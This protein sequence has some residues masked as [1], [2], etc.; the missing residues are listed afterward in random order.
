M[1]DKHKIIIAG[2][3]GRIAGKVFRIGHMGY[4]CNEELLSITLDALQKSFAD[5]GFDTKCNLK[6]KF[7]EFLK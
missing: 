1:K 2:S 7:V 6:E 5:L 3:F 4:I